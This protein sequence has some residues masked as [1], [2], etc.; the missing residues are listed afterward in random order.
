MII[1]IL[2]H[3]RLSA[4]TYSAAPDLKNIKGSVKE[5][6]KHPVKIGGG[7]A[8]NTVYVDNTPADKNAQPFTWMITGN[9]NLNI[10]GYSLPFSFNYTNRKV[11]YTNPAFKFNRL[12]LNPRYKAWTAHIGDVSASFSPY[13]LSG[14]QYTGAG[15]EY[16]KGRWQA[17]AL[18]GRFLRAVKEETNITPSWLRMGWGAK[19]VYN[20]QGKKIGLSLFHAEDNTNSI[21]DPVLAANAAIR[22]MEG[23][24]FAI[25]A[26][27]PVIKKLLVHAEFSTSVLNRDLRLSNSA[28]IPA[29]ASYNKPSEE[30]LQTLLA[31]LFESLL[32]NVNSSVEVYHAIK[33]GATYSF[34]QSS[35]GVTYERVDPGYQTLGGYFFTNDFENVTANFSQN[36]WKGKIT[37]SLNTGLQRDDLANTKKS[38]MKR[39]L[40]SGNMS[41]RPSPKLT[42]GITYSNMKSYTFLRNDFAKINEVTPYQNLDTLNFTQLTQN[43]GVNINYNVLQTK[44]QS[45]SLSFTGNYMEGANQKGD[46]IRFGDLTRFFN[47]SLNYSLTLPANNVTLAAGFMYSYNYAARISGTTKGP[48]LTVSK[49]FFN[50][51]LRTNCGISYNTANSLEK[52]TRVMN[53]RCGASATLAK[54][55]NLNMSLIRQNKTGGVEETV[56]FTAT[57]GYGYGF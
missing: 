51:I 17:H 15:I 39:L 24:A 5:K 10:V 50:K 4:Q 34:K 57:V 45:Q 3:G 53:I 20:D 54:K 7:A 37:A 43:E 19:V 28:P 12:S 13:T 25:E 44:T 41:I 42:V 29:T 14:F 47:G 11:Q 35:V 31:P 30:F 9:L 46:I 8:L 22:P 6:L 40:L 26:A 52:T 33:T 49:L 32:R 2:L 36:F 56:Y 1:F 55:H 18:Y 38:N 48:L 27:W 16:N 23:T 21:P